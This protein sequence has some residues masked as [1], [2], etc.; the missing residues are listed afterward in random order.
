MDNQLIKNLSWEASSKI[1]VQLMSL[2]SALVMTKLLT[3]EDYGIFGVL[4][5]VFMV[6][7]ILQDLSLN[8]AY[9]QFGKPSEKLLNTVFWSLGFLGI[10]FFVLFNLL[11]FI[12]GIFNLIE[13]HVH[14]YI[15]LSFLLILAGFGRGVRMYAIVQG[16]FKAIAISDV[17]SI[18]ISLPIGILMAYNGLGV[19][20]L[21]IQFTLK[22]SLQ[23]FILWLKL[24]WLPR[25]IFDFQEIQNLRKFS[26]QRT[27]QKVSD[28]VFD[29][30]DVIVLQYIY[31]VNTV[32]S[33]VKAKSFTNQGSSTFSQLFQQVIFRYSSSKG[34]F[35]KR[36]IYYLLLL[37]CI[38][39]LPLAIFFNIYGAQLFTY[40]FSSHW[41]FSGEL[42]SLL[43][44]LIFLQPLIF[45]LETTLNG[46]NRVKEVLLTNFFTKVLLVLGMISLFFIS[47]NKFILIYLT[48]KFMQLLILCVLFYNIDLNNEK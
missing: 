36:N 21:T 44:I 45:N 16:N 14:Y 46:L 1:I 23:H 32:G 28:H 18:V 24:K 25:F 7:S 17:L 13:Y 42:F 43:S 11:S 4:L 15:L 6:F 10:V 5:T 19:Y 9:I 3:P 29:N 22:Y 40:L 30:F 37:I 27:L 34:V 20:S 8:E 38:M 35:V 48:S 2:G 12:F 39:T 26:T 41:S 33:Y 31:P 47:I